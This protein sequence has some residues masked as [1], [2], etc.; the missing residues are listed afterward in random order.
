MHQPSH[1]VV[2]NQVRDLIRGEQFSVS[3][4]MEQGV[5]II[6][7]GSEGEDFINV[8]S[9]HYEDVVLERSGKLVDQEKDI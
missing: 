2:V 1:F 8:S 3:M 9:N 5:T 7:R 4:A 6:L